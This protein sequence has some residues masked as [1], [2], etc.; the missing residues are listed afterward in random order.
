MVLLLFLYLGEILSNTSRWSLP[1][2]LYITLLW[3]ADYVFRRTITNA[4]VF[5]LLRI[6]IGAPIAL[7]FS[8]EVTF[9]LL[10]I[11]Y[12][13]FFGMGIHFW[14]SEEP[15]GGQQFLPVDVPTEG[16]MLFVFVFIHAS[17]DMSAKLANYAYI[18]GII[19]V[20]L[21]ILR[22]YLDRFLSKMYSLEENP[23]ALLGFFRMNSAMIAIFLFMI[24]LFVVVVDL[25]FHNKE[26][27]LIGQLL[28]A[29][30]MF[31]FGM[32]SRLDNGTPPEAEQ[33]TTLPEGAAGVADAPQGDVVPPYFTPN[34]NPVMNALFRV[35]E[36]AVYVGLV[37]LVL[38][39]IYAFLKQ[40][41]HRNHNRQ[42]IVED[43]T[44]QNERVKL[45][46]TKPAK[47]AYHFLSPAARVRRF[48]LKYIKRKMK[49]QPAFVVTYSSTPKELQTQLKQMDPQPEVQE[50]QNT[51]TAIYEEARYS[52][53]A[54]SS[55]AVST[56]K[57]L[58]L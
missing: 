49:E 28:R 31:F 40:Y 30:A 42:D 9:I 23:E 45:P 8:D 16:V 22:S 5:V 15:A 39:I 54:I 20:L 52:N 24:L 53:H 19:Y 43:L 55:K 2:I 3:I 4:I 7:F 12:F 35:F 48:Y 50:A 6:V 18:L 47:E 26:L 11:I 56:L 27:N 10:C 21:C 14:K 1:A 46:E 32:L 33:P 51:L 34:E 58:K 44:N 29:I 57:S 41:L 36:I 37:V 25:M 13:A 17:M 38:Y